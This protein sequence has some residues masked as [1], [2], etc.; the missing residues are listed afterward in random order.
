[1]RRE[2]AQYGQGSTWRAMKA[3]K[4]VLWRKRRAVSKKTAVREF[5]STD[6]RT[7]GRNAGRRICRATID[8][9][10]RAHLLCTTRSSGARAQ[11]D[12]GAYSAAQNRSRSCPFSTEGEANEE[13]LRFPLAESVEKSRHTSSSSVL[14]KGADVFRFRRR[15]TTTASKA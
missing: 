12:R 5:L 3:H 1:M 11:I 14:R 10:V 2:R 8:V 15:G 9:L 6:I 4:V 13:A 7:S